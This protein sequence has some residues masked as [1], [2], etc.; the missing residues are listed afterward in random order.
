MRERV[1]A[2]FARHG[3]LIEEAQLWAAFLL[4]PPAQEPRWQHH[5]VPRNNA[6]SL[7]ALFVS[8]LVLSLR[9]LHFG[10][11]LIQ[12]I[13]A[14][15]IGRWWLLPNIRRCE[16]TTRALFPRIFLRMRGAPEN[17]FLW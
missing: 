3:V 9:L 12:S 1:N 17:V 4:L 7:C 14:E 10:K 5:R 15:H 11:G 6:E 13:Q 8:T 2:H 16:V